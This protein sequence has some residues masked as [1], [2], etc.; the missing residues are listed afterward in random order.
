MQFTKM[1]GL[2]NDYVIV[3]ALPRPELEATR[4]WSALAGAISDRHE[5][6]GSDGL[7]LVCPPAAGGHARM[8]IFNADGGEAEMCGNGIRCVAALL[9]GR[10]EFGSEALDIETA[11][12]VRRCR[13]GQG[14][15]VL[16]EMGEPRVGPEVCGVVATHLACEDPCVVRSGD[17]DIAFE[18]VSV[19]NPHAVVFADR[20][21]WIGED[22]SRVVRTIG[23]QMETHAAFAEGVNVQ[24]LRIDRRDRA[25]LHTWERGSGVTR[26]CGTGACAAM[27]AAVLA[28]ALDR[29][30]TI[31]LPGGDLRLSWTPIDD[32]GDGVVRMEGPAVRSFTG[33]LAEDLADLEVRGRAMRTAMVQSADRYPAS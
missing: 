12:G 27:A 25:T 26:A 5:G 18:L 29:V 3:D 1:H 14:G 19:G 22:L 2:G 24:L 31:T 21:A 33:T 23:P 10:P 17:R 15:A 16:V 32:G 13:V 30:A 8:R 11:A 9:R 28:G 7:I 6:V 20:H 4:D